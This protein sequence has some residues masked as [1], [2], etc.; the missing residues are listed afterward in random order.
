MLTFWNNV[1]TIFI[2]SEVP[3][4]TTCEDGA[5]NVTKRRYIKFRRWGIT[6]KKEYNKV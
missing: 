1:S 5:D 2:G 6:Q 4:Y 3:A